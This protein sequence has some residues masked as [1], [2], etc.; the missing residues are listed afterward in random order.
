MARSARSNGSPGYSIRLVSELTGLGIETLRQ[1]ERRYG[2][3]RPSRNAGGARVYDVE[4]VE[5]LKLLA[6]AIGRGYRPSELVGRS[7]AQIERAL[8]AVSAGSAT[9]IG[10]E[11]GIA[12]VI[13]ALVA[14]DPLRLTAHLRDAALRYGPRRFVTELVADLV[15]SVG[16]LWEEKR[17]EVRHEHLLS[18]VLTTQLRVMRASFA[19]SRKGP[20]VTLATLP[21]EL[22]GLGIEMVAVYAA[23][24]GASVRVIGVDTPPDQIA[25]AARNLGA[26]AVGVSISES[27]DLRAAT[28]HLKKLAEALPEEIEL[29]IGGRGAEGVAVARAR[30]VIGFADLDRALDQL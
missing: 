10:A 5:T 22:H 11:P 2:F 29:W 30:S 24:A 17:I 6:R 18:D 16:E 25:E 28:K 14:D 9:E 15:R 7:R 1:W 19:E 26:R 27:S 8:E 3:P 23:A 13:D 4:T 21:G 20:I 12:D